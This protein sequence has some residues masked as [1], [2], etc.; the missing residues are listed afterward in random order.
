MSTQD[1]PRPPTPQG[2]KNKSDEVIPRPPTPPGYPSTSEGSN[3]REKTSNSQ[4]LVAPNVG[5]INDGREAMMTPSARLAMLP[6]AGTRNENDRVVEHSR[7]TYSSELKEDGVQHSEA[8]SWN[9]Q[10]ESGR[11]GR[12]MEEFVPRK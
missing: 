3:Q 5:T 8:Y 12:A 11:N 7:Y 10:G 9:M 2:H 4:A 6:V 1:I